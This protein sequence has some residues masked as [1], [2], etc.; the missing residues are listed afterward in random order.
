MDSPLA[1]A[2]KYPASPAPRW[3][4]SEEDDAVAAKKVKA[5]KAMKAMKASSDVAT[6]EEGGSVSEGD[7]A[8]S[9]HADNKVEVPKGEFQ[10]SKRHWKRRVREVG[11]DFT[12]S[13]REV[14][15]KRTKNKI[16]ACSTRDSNDRAAQRTLTSWKPYPPYDVEEAYQW[17]V[18]SSSGES[19]LYENESDAEWAEM[20]SMWRQLGW[21]EEQIDAWGRNAGSVQD[22]QRQQREGKAHEDGPSA[23]SL[24]KPAATPSGKLAES[25]GNLALKVD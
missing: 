16:A 20:A 2:A 5:Q 15:R 8:E 25:F 24:S 1:L 19:G 10:H 3:L 11:S 21:S 6:T 23:S 4:G 22:S 17:D 14:P 7:D 18:G 12:T 9:K 13:T